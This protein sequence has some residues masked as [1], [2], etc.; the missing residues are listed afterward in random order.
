M[1]ILNVTPDSFSDGGDF[2]SPEKALLHAIQMVEEGAA[3]IDV[4][5]ESTRPGAAAVSLDQELSRV[6]PVIEAI[7]AEVDTLIS[8]DTSK[9]VVMTAAVQAGASMI[10]DVRALQEQGAL[11]VAAALQVPVCLMHMKGWPQTMQ[12]APEY[13]DVVTEVASFLQQRIDCC[14]AAGVPR[15]LLVIDPGFGFGKTLEHNQAL[16]RQLD[17]LL[18]F[19][20]PLLVGVSRKSMIAQML[21]LS[22][23]KRHYGSISLASI[24]VWQGASIIRAHDVSAT[25]QAI[26]VSYMCKVEEE[27]G[28]Q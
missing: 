3:I 17:R 16:L 2:F 21:N 11:E 13:S 8:I 15:E 7:R 27:T 12:S 9:P 22:A 23:D 10:N 25:A 5:G 6:I 24:A 28:K 19:E 20:L 1:G 26:Q 14:I 4:G 18:A